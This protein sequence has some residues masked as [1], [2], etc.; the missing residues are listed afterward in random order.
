[1]I[2]PDCPGAVGLYGAP[3]V[4]ID[5][6]RDGAM[7]D[8]ISNVVDLTPDAA[9]FLTPAA[10]G[11]LYVYGEAL[12]P[13]QR[14]IVQGDC[15]S[16][17][18]PGLS[19]PTTATTCVFGDTTGGNVNGVWTL[20][21]EPPLPDPPPFPVTIIDIIAGVEGFMNLASAPP[22]YMIDIIGTGN[23]V[24]ECPPD[25]AVGVIPDVVLNIEAFQGKKYEIVTGC[26]SVCP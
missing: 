12:L 18:T 6:D 21:Q 5:I 8:N 4:L 25:Q 19:D 23:D 20:C 13:G 24:F 2:T 17:G 3:P 9:A 26:P 11:D 22:L 10:W 1:M 15:G 16:P 14:Y 7:D